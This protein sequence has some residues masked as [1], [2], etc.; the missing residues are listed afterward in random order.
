MRATT[1]AQPPRIAH[2]PFRRRDASDARGAIVAPTR[3]RPRSPSAEARPSA[4]PLERAIG[5]REGPLPPLRPRSALRPSR[6]PASSA[7]P[8]HAGSG[9]DVVSRALVR[10]GFPLPAPIRADFDRAFADAAPVR[11]TDDTG[12]QPVGGWLI[13]RPD[14]PA[15]LRAAEVASRA[16]RPSAGADVVQTGPRFDSVRV[17]DDRSAARAASALGARA[18][19]LGEDI[20]FAA[21]RYQPWSSAGRELIAHELTHV[22]QAHESGP[23]IMREVSGDVDKTSPEYL[24]GYND[25]R[26]N[27]QSAA[28][29]LTAEGLAEYDAG[30]SRGLA[31]ATHAQKS[32]PPVTAVHEVEPS[33]PALP[34]LEERLRVIEETG[35]A[36]HARL[37]EIVRY[38]GPM[39]DTSKGARV[40]FAAI[41]D[42]E[43]YE[44]HTEIRAI[45]GADTDALGK[46]APVYHASTP[47]ARTLSATQGKRTEKGGREASILGPRKESIFSHINDA[48]IKGFEDIIPGLP[49]NPRGTIYFTTARIAKG[50]AEPVPVPA[51]AGCIRASFE[52]HHEFHGVDLVT[53]APPF[54]PL[55]T[56]DFGEPHVGHGE[57]GE[58]AEPPAQAGEPPA[59]TA[60][61]GAPAAGETPHVKAAGGKSV[62]ATEAEPAGA[63]P[64]AGAT[65]A[66]RS[67]GAGIS[68]EMGIHIGTGIATLGLGWLAARLKARVD[69]R[70]AQ[71]QI[72]AFLEV[73]R[74]RI[75]ANP[76]EALKKMLSAPE[77]T[78][79][80]W[81]ALDSSVIS[82]VGVDITSPEPVMTDSSPLLDWSRIDYEYA[83]VPQELVESF[84]RIS[85]FGG[86]HITMARTITID[87][88]LQTPPL[89]VLISDA[90]ARSLPL[91]DLFAYA[92]TRY[93][94]AVSSWQTSSEAHERIVAA[95]QSTLD[96][97][98]QL[99]ARFRTA[100]KLHDVELQ[101]RIA[102]HL[103]AIAKSLTTT[104]LAERLKP[105]E[106]GEQRA[107]KN[108]NYW[109]HILGLINPPRP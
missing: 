42:V 5:P 95:Y 2:E 40:I 93:Q 75:N 105:I 45:N 25:G 43:G 59:Q 13:G 70:Q 55:S 38:G 101:K 3:A 18:F 28:G 41:V 57:H 109:Q 51:C 12:A 79:Y 46:G 30:Y 71:K 103:T 58:R 34:G 62:T 73:A 63:V 84:P 64:P 87:I 91:D 27:S 74:R 26:A 10:N 31:E 36:V 7:T 4:I 68:S 22:L 1:N 83:P 104:P 108:V 17:H 20:F 97:F 15:E 88:P 21:G 29:P 72:D 50:E 90:R 23:V 32:L 48:E 78:V 85:S 102:G 94:A 9:R 96:A 81:V 39:P 61:I 77:A 16:M 8:R 65:P 86:S 52:A 89:E 44:G 76:D 6:V 24:R 66:A 92:T 33:A 98:I 54:P 69:A 49:K 80:A 106:E 82:T 60:T 53:H 37:D 47:T 35:P 11:R 56:I 99:Q 19:T 100:Q 107:E 14:S 67:I